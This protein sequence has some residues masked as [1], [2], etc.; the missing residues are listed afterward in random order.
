MNE[1][2]FSIHLSANQI[3]DDVY[4]ITTTI[5]EEPPAVF[6][7]NTEMKN[8]IFSMQDYINENPHKIRRI[9]MYHTQGILN[10]V[11]LLRE[12]ANAY[13]E[14]N[15]ELPN[16]L[17]C[18]LVGNPAIKDLSKNAVVMQNE[19]IPD[20]I[21]Q[22]LDDEEI[23][24]ELTYC[25]SGTAARF[26]HGKINKIMCNSLMRIINHYNRRPKLWYFALTQCLPDFMEWVDRHY[27]EEEE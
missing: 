26:I 3:D 22:Q 2:S 12:R 13:Y 16:F 21:E 24:Y 11:W 4:L 6:A 27:G 8:A 5:S 23:I 9:L 7:V 25:K 15:P 18:P 20:P 14:D 17:L 1:D 10:G 19:N